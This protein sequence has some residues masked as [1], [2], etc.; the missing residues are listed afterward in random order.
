MSIEQ[1]FRNAGNKIK[2]EF[3][4]QKQERERRLSTPEFMSEMNREKLELKRQF[5]ETSVKFMNAG[6]SII[7]DGMGA[8]VK[9]GL[10]MV[11]QSKYGADKAIKDTIKGGGKAAWKTIQFLASA[12]LLTGKA[13]KVLARY[14]VA[15]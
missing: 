8:P 11:S 6:S 1:F 5:K 2:S 14:L 3:E 12:G 9:A 13:L 15:K 4:N 7:M 10:K